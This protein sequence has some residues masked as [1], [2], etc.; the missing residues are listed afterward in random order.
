MRK[1]GKC[2]SFTKP[3]LCIDL[4]DLRTKGFYR[5]IIVNNVS[6]TLFGFLVNFVYF[7][8]ADDDDNLLFY[9]LLSFKEFIREI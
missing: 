6:L 9:C 1:N 5:P 4:P 2:G 3:V 7:K 8:D